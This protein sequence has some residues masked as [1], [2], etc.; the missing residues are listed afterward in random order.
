MGMSRICCFSNIR[1]S[2]LFLFLLFTVSFFLF[3][4]KYIHIYILFQIL[5]PLSLL[6]NIEQSV[7]YRRSLL[8]THFKYSSVDMCIP[9]SPTIPSPTLLPATISLQSLWVFF[10]FGWTGWTPLSPWLLRR[11]RG[12][13]WGQ[14]RLFSELMRGDTHARAVS[15]KTM[16]SVGRIGTRSPREF[17][18]VNFILFQE[19]RLK[20]PDRHG[21]FMDE[22]GGILPLPRGW[23]LGGILLRDC[24]LQFFP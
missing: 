13:A 1:G 16:P 14:I 12:N 17:Q 19:N 8:V 6:H 15:Q 20:M 4:K 23:I 11:R 10:F 5:F 9:N 24:H 2:F 18:R 7:P 22:E 3:L 21:E